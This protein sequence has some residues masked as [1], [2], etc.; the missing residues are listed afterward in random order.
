MTPSGAQV[1]LAQ[2]VRKAMEA[3]RGPG[4]SATLSGYCGVASAVLVHV[5]R[6]GGFRATYVNGMYGAT[7]NYMKNRYHTWVESNGFIWDVTATQFGRRER[8]LVVNK[9]KARAFNKGVGTTSVSL[10]GLGQRVMEAI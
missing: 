8:V 5:F 6:K 10:C 1:R 3:Y 7:G 9:A 2:R 4:R